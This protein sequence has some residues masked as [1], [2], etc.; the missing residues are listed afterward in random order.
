MTTQKQKKL[1][2]AGWTVGDAADF[3]GLTPEEAQLVAIRA[4][5]SRALRQRRRDLRWNQTTLARKIGTSQAR[6]AKAEGAR[7]G[8]S[9]DFFIQALVAT[10]ADG[11]MIGRIVGGED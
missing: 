7:A 5:L 1:E 9:I 10:G 3:L 11:K 8:I 4:R 2:A 6:I